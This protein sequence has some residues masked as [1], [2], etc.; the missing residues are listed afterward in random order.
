MSG[1]IWHKGQLAQLRKPQQAWR[2]G[3]AG[4]SHENQEQIHH[5]H[6]SEMGFVL[7]Q[8]QKLEQ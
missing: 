3:N 1:K 7:Q 2:C 4:R 8:H 6:A 5:W